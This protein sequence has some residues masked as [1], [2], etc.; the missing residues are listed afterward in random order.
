[1]KKHP[2]FYFWMILLFT[3]LSVIIDMPKTKPFSIIIPKLPGINR[4]FSFSLPFAGSTIGKKEFSFKKGLDLAG[5]TSITLH[6]DMS[7]VPNENRKDALDATRIIL[8]RRVNLYGVSEPTIQTA[9]VG[10]DYRLI[11]DLPGIDVNQA[12][13]LIGTTAQ[14][15]FWEQGASGS[16]QFRNFPQLLPIGMLQILGPDARETILTG[17]DLKSS[18]VSFNSQTG[19]PEVQIVFTSDGA[20]KFADLTQKNLGKLLVMVLDNIVISAPR[21]NQ[22]ILDGNA[23][24]TGNFTTDQAK[25][26][27][28]QLQAGAL[29]VP[30]SI[31]E[32]RTIGAT[33]GTSSL[34]KSLFAGILGFGFIVFFMITLYGRYGV[35][36]STALVLYIIFALTIFKIIPV[37][38]T[39]AGIAGF[40]LS[41]GMAVDANILIFERIKEEIRDGKDQLRALELGFA[42]AWPSIRDS[43]ISTLITSIILYQFG[44]G[45]VRG[46]A[47]TLA[48]GV[49]LSMFS[50]I[51]VTRTLLRLFFKR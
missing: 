2:H 16:G 10:N 13:N 40:I 9:L 47:L 45:I 22:P 17:K 37:T 48:V 23:V 21:V 1:M 6:A 26:L 38:L 18:A 20:K 42:R 46:F 33:L 31:L 32:Q 34:I 12:V 49:L 7:H 51:I 5:G 15:T 41:I 39:L 11:V 43:N 27:S 36:A 50:A 35:T 24:I 14:L 4:K 25:N 3:V 8:E 19:S 44:T 29:P 30:L 28:I